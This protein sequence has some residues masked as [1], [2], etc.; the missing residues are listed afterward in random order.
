MDI[1]TGQNPIALTIAQTLIEGFNK[2]Y[3][4][5]R[6]RSIQ[7]KAWFEEGDWAGVQQAVRERIQ[8][9]DDRVRETE[10]RLRNEL[11]APSL[12]DETWH[13]VKLL[14]VG[15]LTNHKQPEL[16]ETFF[17]SVFCRIM[18]RTYFHNEFIFFRPA[19]STEY[20]ESDPPTYRTY[21]PTWEGLGETFRRVIAD[22]QW[23]C[24][25]ADLPRDL[26]FVVESIE[27]YLG[28]WPPAEANLQ[29]QVLSSAFYRNK[30]AY[31]VGK[32]VNGHQEY[33]FAIP[34]L[35]NSK[36]E[37]Y[38]DTILL[39]AWRIGLLFSL[40]RAYF[41]VDMEVPSAYVQFLRS[42][43]PWKSHA[44]LY[45]ILG[46]QKQGKNMFYR[47]LM[48]HLRHS[49][50]EFI[51]APGIPGLVMHV[52]TLPSF[53]YVFKVIQD[54]FR[55]PKEVDH[56]IVKAKYQLVKRHDRVGR[57]A[58]TLEF[59]DVALPRARMSQEL[60]NELRRT[61]AESLQE[62]GAQVIIKHVYIERRIQPLNLY[63]DRASAEQV[64]QAVRDYGNAI[65]ELA[66]A[67]I[68]PGDMLFKNFGITRYGRVVFYDYDELEY[69]T[70]CNFRRIPAPP[71]PEFEMSDEPWYA[72]ARN[73]VFPEEFAR[74]L[75]G[76]P[77][78]REAFYRHH[79][80][81]LTTEFWHEA[82]QRVASG[83][84]GD[85]FPYPESLRFRNAFSGGEPGE[86]Q[87]EAAPEIPR[88]NMPHLSPDLLSEVEID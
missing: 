48:H 87:R 28:G 39:D 17:N 55:P 15:L 88:A 80:D 77:E 64:D 10:E 35:R 22:F 51:I 1:P 41:M 63:L 13:Q 66:L 18:H 38:L 85:F 76:S 83:Q 78:I 47:H 9:Y 49:R 2:H 79:P 4:L 31:I 6:G 37:L 84:F 61:C 30:A 69:L 3:R 62:D 74:F 56:A 12:D 75:L 8:F 73:D 34:V 40:T 71:N 45:T 58:D 59:S 70:D 5:F 29:L 19:V 33:P 67:N 24:P 36:G 65:K 11:H 68:F 43:M 42:I 81:L 21:H 46:L 72:V 16:A 57:M 53:P 60:V 7:A 26:E 86:Q 44:D 54:K 50:D 23:R 32:M 27:R 52:F 25:F 82:Q 20:I 14:Y